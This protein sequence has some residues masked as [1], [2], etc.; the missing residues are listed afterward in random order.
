M[1][2]YSDPTTN[3]LTLSLYYYTFNA[4]GGNIGF[5]HVSDRGGRNP[6]LHLN[7][8]DTLLLTLYNMVP[9]DYTNA[10]ITTTNLHFHGMI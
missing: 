6:A 7:P 3:S 4:D 10:T 9:A 1:H 5:C 8:G 2:Y